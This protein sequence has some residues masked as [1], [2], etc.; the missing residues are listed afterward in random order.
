MLEGSEPSVT[1]VETGEVAGWF[2]STSPSVELIPRTL[3]SFTVGIQLEQIRSNHTIRIVWPLGP[4]Q[5]GTQPWPR[6]EVA[7]AHLDRFVLIGDVTCGERARGTADRQ[8]AP[9]QPGF[10]P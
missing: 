7:Y 4:M 5:D 9:Q 2:G 10:M 3:G 8:P 6:A 1:V